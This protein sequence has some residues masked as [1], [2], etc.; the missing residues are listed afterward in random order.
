[1]KKIYALI[2]ALVLIT[3][4]TAC[5]DKSVLHDESN[6]EQGVVNLN[7]SQKESMDQSDMDI[8]DTVF[9]DGTAIVR[10]SD[11]DNINEGY[12]ITIIIQKNSEGQTTYSMFSD[13]AHNMTASSVPYLFFNAIDELIAALGAYPHNAITNV[14][15]QHS[16]DFSKEEIQ[17]LTEKIIIPSENYS[18]ATVVQ[19]NLAPNT[20]LP[21]IMH[22][23]VIYYF[24]SRRQFDIELSPSFDAPKI[25]STVPLSQVP[26]ENGQAN[27][28]G[29]DFGG[30]GSLY[31]PYNDGLLVYWND[32]WAYFV[33][34]EQLTQSI[35]D[36]IERNLD[37]I[38]SSPGYHSSITPYIQAHQAEYNEIVALCDTAHTY[39]VALFEKGGQTDLRSWIM[40]FAC[41]DILGGDDVFKPSAAGT[42]QEWF[43]ENKELINGYLLS[44]GLN[45]SL[46]DIVRRER[47]NGGY[48]TLSRTY[49]I[50][51]LTALPLT[52]SILLYRYIL[53][54]R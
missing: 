39:M 4:L 23:G 52:G 31:T 6:S 32:R 24:D 48:D 30:F 46:T 8:G 38:T 36:I 29:S 26:Q 47:L 12:T 37:I 9:N 41:R 45:E 42:G 53:L 21:Q 34:L 16:I 13:N 17:A 2:L 7:D 14:Y 28:E 5:K 15:V 20:Y 22:N 11:D 43:D 33:P 27:F 44:G 10:G 51:P 40:A 25:T 54:F 35:A 49:S 50:R 3:A 18:M 1:M 19:Q